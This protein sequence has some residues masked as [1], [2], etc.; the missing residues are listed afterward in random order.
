MRK[1]NNKVCLITVIVHYDFKDKLTFKVTLGNM[2]N[3]DESNKSAELP[4][5]DDESLPE[6][7]VEP[8][9]EPRI[10]SKMHY[11]SGAGQNDAHTRALLG[12]ESA[13]MTNAQIRAVTIKL[14]T[15]RAKCMEWGKER[16]W[17]GILNRL[18]KKG[19]KSLEGHNITLSCEVN[20]LLRFTPI[21]KIVPIR[22]AI[23][24]C[25]YGYF[26]KKKLWQLEYEKEYMELN[27][28]KYREGSRY[29]LA[30]DE[31]GRGCIAR[32]MSVANQKVIKSINND[33]S[34]V[35]RQ[36]RKNRTSEQVKEDDK[37]R[38]GAGK[39]H[40]KRKKGPRQIDETRLKNLRE[41]EEAF[42][43]QKDK[44]DFYNER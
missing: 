12:E 8:G 37:V 23:Y 4:H 16:I 25:S 6:D 5:G 11:V 22:D 39:T 9:V 13:G 17:T 18:R 15:E 30:K 10:I 42:K 27:N 2:N 32:L 43:K 14:N 7:A 19:V 20:Q 26:E 28:M 35:E 24:E 44:L 3:D 38:K 33:V 1:R 29:V 31:N 34:M 40:T 36:V 41:L 21:E